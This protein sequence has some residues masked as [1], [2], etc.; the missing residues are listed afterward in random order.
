MV[1]GEAEKFMVVLDDELD[2]TTI[3]ADDDVLAA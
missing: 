1:V 2:A 3:E